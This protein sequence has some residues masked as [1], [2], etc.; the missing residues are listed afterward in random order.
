MQR[1]RGSP[2]TFGALLACTASSAAV[3]FAWQQAPAEKPAPAEK[4]APR[5]RMQYF[6]DEAKTSLVFHDVQAI[7]PKRVMAVGSVVDGRSSKPV[8]VVTQDGGE[9]WQLSPIDENPISL[10][11][12]D[13]SQ[14]WM[15]TEKGLWHTDEG[16]KDWRKLPKLPA[17]PVRVHFVDANN[18]W[19]A[20]AKKTVLVTHD[21]GR[22]W[23]PVPAAAEPA[24]AP[25]RSVY[26]WIAFGNAN[27]G[28][29]TGLNQPVPRWLPMFPTALDPE[30]ALSRRETAHLS[31]KLTTNDGGK[32]WKTESA[33]LIGRISKIRLSSN[34]SGLGLI[35]YADSFKYAS[36]VYQVD[37][38]TGKNTTVFRD[39]KFA[40]TDVW[41]TPGGTAYL[42]GIES[43]GQVRSVA[44]GKVKVV[45]SNDLQ[46]WTE[47][48]V[49]YRAVAQRVLLAGAGEDVWLTTNDGMILKWK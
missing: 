44:P 18:G 30:D 32:T 41:L 19:A 39:K 38:K 33:S 1:K 6:Y 45:T 13:E 22:K 29:I 11:F 21:G 7:S 16:G 43:P 40:V 35:E 34:G 23:D 15:V 46:S 49:D 5:W 28:I 20:C 25:E 42:A 37:W 2:Q 27:Y 26:N 24:G 8:S 3:L 48:P 4:Q 31:Y 36:E 47:L 10:F 14:G 17:Q 12:L 9:H